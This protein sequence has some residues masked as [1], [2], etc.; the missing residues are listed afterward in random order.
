M[1]L[2][3]CWQLS[4]PLHLRH[5]S[6]IRDTTLKAKTTVY[7]YFT[8]D[9]FQKL[10]D[11]GK[12]FWDAVKT[13]PDGATNGIN[14]AASLDAQ[15]ELDDYGFP[16]LDSSLFEGHNNDATLEGCASALKADRFRISRHDPMLMKQFDGTY[17]M[18]M[19]LSAVLLL[20]C[21]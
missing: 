13:V 4:Q 8:F 5:L 2:V 21:H 17:G 6:I 10:V 12:R 15:P 1:R 20:T 18:L 9:N 3:E 7:T 14:I 19:K 16:V 11:Q